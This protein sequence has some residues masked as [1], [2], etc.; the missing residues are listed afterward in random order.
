MRRVRK[1]Q[2]TVGLSPE[3]AHWLRARSAETKVPRPAFVEKAL[4]DFIARYDAAVAAKARRE[5]A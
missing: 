4:R 1:E 2:I 5:A 3:V